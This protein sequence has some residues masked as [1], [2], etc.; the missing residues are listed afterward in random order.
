MAIK[1]WRNGERWRH[2]QMRDILNSVSRSGH[3]AARWNYNEEHSIVVISVAIGF[4]IFLLIPFT[5]I[6]TV[7]GV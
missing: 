6:H 4:R 3:S 1:E 7:Q 5:I 2:K